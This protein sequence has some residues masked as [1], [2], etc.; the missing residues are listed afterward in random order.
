[1]VKRNGEGVRRKHHGRGVVRV[2]GSESTLDM[3]VVG[4]REGGRKKDGRGVSRVKGSEKNLHM[5]VVGRKGG[6]DGVGG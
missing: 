2:K 4:G 1:M 6:T 5:G 3:G